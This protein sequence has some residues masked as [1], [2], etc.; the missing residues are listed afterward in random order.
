MTQSGQNHHLNCWLL[1]MFLCLQN[2]H[3]LELRR[4]FKF[5]VANL[6]VKREIRMIF[7]VIPIFPNLDINVQN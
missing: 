2:V 3:R 5:W 7:Y 4:S 6:P 1:Y